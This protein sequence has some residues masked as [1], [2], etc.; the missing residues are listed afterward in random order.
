MIVNGVI[1]CEN[2]VVAILNLMLW[3]LA[4]FGYR[5][6]RIGWFVFGTV[7]SLLFVFPYCLGIVGYSVETSKDRI[8]PISIL[9]LFDRLLPAYRIRE[10][11]YNIQ[12]YYVVSKTAGDLPTRAFRHL[13]KKWL[14]VQATE[15]QRER[16]ERYLDLLRFSGLV[17]TIFILAA[18]S[19]LTR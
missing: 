12:Q 10:E 2:L 7:L 4:D 16:I 8:K 9:F 1:W 3:V 19:K 13:G 5:P 11:H 18:V 6:E 17:F 15:Q 14:V